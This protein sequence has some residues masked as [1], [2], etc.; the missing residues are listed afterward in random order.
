MS[1]HAP[2]CTFPSLALTAWL[3]MLTGR[4]QAE[5]AQHETVMQL[6]AFA[7]RAEQLREV[8]HVTALKLSTNHVISARTME[9]TLLELTRILDEEPQLRESPRRELVAFLKESSEAWGREAHGL[10]DEV[11]MPRTAAAVATAERGDADAD[12]DADAPVASNTEVQ[13]LFARALMSKNELL[14][15]LERLQA[16]VVTK[17]LELLAARTKRAEAADAHKA[18]SADRVSE[19][20]A[21][22]AAAQRAATER[23]AA[24]EALA[25]QLTAAESARAALDAFL[26]ALPASVRN[27]AAEGLMPPDGVSPRSRSAAAELADANRSLSDTAGRVRRARARRATKASTAGRSS[28]RE[29]PRKRS[30]SKPSPRERARSAQ[31][32]QGAGAPAAAADAAAADAKRSAEEEEEAAADQARRD[33]AGLAWRQAAELQVQPGR[34][35]RDR[36]RSVVGAAAEA[37]T[38]RQQHEEEMASTRQ[39]MLETERE[40]HAALT[41]R[42]R[43]LRVA[44]GG[45]RRVEDQLAQA[46]AFKE[47]LHAALDLARSHG[48]HSETAWVEMMD[49]LREKAEVDAATMHAELVAVLSTKRRTREARL[50]SKAAAAFSND[51]LAFSALAASRASAPSGE[52]ADTASLTSTWAP[53]GAKLQR[54]PAKTEIAT[55][56]TGRRAPIMGQDDSQRTM[57]AHPA[58]TGSAGELGLERQ[59]GSGRELGSAKLVR[60]PSAKASCESPSRES[61][62]PDSSPSKQSGRYAGSRAALVARL[63]TAG[64]RSYEDGAPAGSLGQDG[65]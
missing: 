5:D 9:R 53:A 49:A 7:G 18:T 37:A 10:V 63:V 21:S 32:A 12:A 19:L 39:Q 23:A 22:R 4:A 20:A 50:A 2:T 55:R 52:D 24:D 31:G 64:N 48:A 65:D 26:E 25:E 44:E 8:A 60:L 30:G 54:R 15:E 42:R 58:A 6:Q 56:M 40:L 16:E 27:Q 14:L 33:M 38:K 29:G 62:A 46:L 36:L 41:Q 45:R 35:L 51:T 57:V 17:S 59:L 28:P 3:A 11:Q 61:A 34:T 43:E 47:R 13:A 1:P